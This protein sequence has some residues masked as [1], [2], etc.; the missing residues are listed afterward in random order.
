MFRKY[1]AKGTL[2][3]ERHIEGIQVDPFLRTLPTSWAARSGAG[4]DAFPIVPASVRAAAV[5]A[6][7]QLWISL[8]VPYTYVYDSAGDKQRII[9]FRGAGIISPTSFFFTHDNRLLVTPGCY[10]FSPRL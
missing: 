8:A 1:D 5:D 3:F 2:V 10:A 6:Q 9:Q 4:R 7:G